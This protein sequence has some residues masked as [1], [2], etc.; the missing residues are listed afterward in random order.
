MGRNLGDH[1]KGIF[2]AVSN[3]FKGKSDTAVRVASTKMTHS[4]LKALETPDYLKEQHAVAAAAAAS[5][6]VDSL[7]P[8]EFQVY[9]TEEE[10][11]KRV[12][13]LSDMS[14]YRLASLAAMLPAEGIQAAPHASQEPAAPQEPAGTEAAAA[15]QEPG[16]QQSV[17]AQE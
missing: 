2:L 16:M 9:T 3:R 1:F 11:S 4:R 8:T 15:P 14:H 5:A 10:V 7:E 6:S 13:T 17:N 12:K